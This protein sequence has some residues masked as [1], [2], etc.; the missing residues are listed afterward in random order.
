MLV[1]VRP[2]SPILD[3]L[4]IPSS[5]IKFLPLR[6]ALDAPSAK[7]LSDLV[8]RHQIE[9]VHA[10]MAR[11][12]SLAAYAT[13]RNQG[14]SFFVTRHVLF[15]L[16]SLHRRTLA[17]AA[18]VIA[19]SGAVGRQLNAQRLTE[20]E[21][22]VVVPNGINLDR[23][24]SARQTF[25]RAAFL[26]SRN[27]PQNCLL[28]GSVGELR[29]L[30]RHDD[31][32]RAAAI[33][34]REVPTAQFVIAG[35]DTT[36]DHR[37]GAGL[38][39]L[40]RELGLEDRIHFLGWVEDAEHLLMALDVF[41]SAS[42]TESFGLA[43]AEAMAAETSVV[44]TSTEGA[45]EVVEANQSGMLVPVGDV[46]QMAEAIV[47]LLLD[48]DKREAFGRRGLEVVEQNFS[49]ERMVNDIEELYQKAKRLRA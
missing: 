3:H 14:A 22:I 40:V 45:R 20:P 4:K 5:N 36:A 16:S 44:S 41:V 29:S 37:I 19:V 35:V 23:F 38:L 43:I 42:E 10:H 26:Q 18:C 33:V 49:L 34:S 46:A 27:L 25:E 7:Q 31:F 12:Y 21:R 47:G 11:D 15:P 28:A 6:N 1:A 8:R 39:Q 17:K 32:I 13:R 2:K 48:V 30:K 9:V 24:A